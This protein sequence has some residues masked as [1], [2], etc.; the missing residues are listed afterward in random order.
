[1]KGALLGIFLLSASNSLA[2]T[3]SEIYLF[4]LKSKKGEVSVSNPINIT[5]HKGYDNQPSFDSE[6]SLIYYSSFNED[7]RADIKIAA[8]A[9]RNLSIVLVGRSRRQVQAALAGAVSG[10]GRIGRPDGASLFTRVADDETAARRR[11]PRRPWPRLRA[12]QS[13]A[14]TAAVRSGRQAIGHQ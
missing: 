5:N 10:T 1:M 3:G 4:D 6:N 8:G 12:G 7:G 11:Q 9:A 2:Q 14:G 13:R